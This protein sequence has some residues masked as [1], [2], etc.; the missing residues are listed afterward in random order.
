[1]MW[2]GVIWEQVVAGGPSEYDR[3]AM[4]PE[5]SIATEEQRQSAGLTIEF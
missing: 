1:M 3:G 2:T 4:N 5:V